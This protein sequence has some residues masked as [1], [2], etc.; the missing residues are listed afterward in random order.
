MICVALLIRWGINVLALIVVDWMFDGVTIGR[1]G[2]LVLAAAILTIG[3]TILKPILAILTLPL[4]IFTFGLAYFAINVLMLALAEWITPDFSIDGFWTYVGATIV[5][6]LVNVMRRL[7]PRPG[8]R[9]GEIA[10]TWYSFLLFAHVAMAVIWIGGGLMMQLFGVRASMLGDRTRLAN[11]GEDIAFIG[12]RL[13]VPASLLAFLTGVLLV[14][15]SDFYGFGD[16][17]I[18]IALVLY[19]TTFLTG[20]LFLGPESGRVGALTAEGSPE[21]GPRRLRLILLLPLRPRAALPHDLRHDGEARLRRCGLD[22]LGRRGCAV[23]AGADLLALS[24]RAGAGRAAARAESSLALELDEH[25]P[26]GDAVALGDVYGGDRSLERRVHGNLHLHRLEDDE[27]LAGADGVARRDLEPNDRAGHRCRHRALA[28]RRSGAMRFEVDVRRRHRRR[29]G[30]IQSPR[31]PERGGRAHDRE[32]REG[33]VLGEERGRCVSRAHHWVR[34]EP[35]EKREIR[36]DAFDVRLGE[37]GSE[38]V[39]RRVAGRC[40]RDELRDHRVVGEADL[41]ALLHAGVDANPMNLVTL[42]HLAAQALDSARLG[43]KVLESSAYR[44]TSTAWPSAC[45]SLLQAP[46]RP[47]FGAARRRGRGR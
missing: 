26:A 46:R 19:A 16:D 23:A 24:R 43:K 3:N 18:V 38:A 27:R 10:V 37:R 41:V 17:W 35:T 42:C 28:V 11:L 21:A 44:R 9:L 34:D 13:F 30:E 39:E 22:P 47:R 14:I 12:P 15:E 4:I 32:G 5:V 45:N 1:W 2:P 40:V 20:L 36:R 25:R 7:D 8:A 33:R 29:R 6:W 31:C